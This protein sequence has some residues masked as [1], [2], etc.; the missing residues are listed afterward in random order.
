ME[1][2][3]T[4]DALLQ[5]RCLFGAIVFTRLL[6]VAFANV[7]FLFAFS[8]NYFFLYLLFVAAGKLL[9]VG[10]IFGTWKYKF[11]P[12]IWHSISTG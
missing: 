1:H 4:V 3:V 9:I 7:V 6:F 11:D 12:C 10:H 5:L 2:I 8:L